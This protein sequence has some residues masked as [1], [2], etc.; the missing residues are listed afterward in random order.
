MESAKSFL[1]RMKN[2]EDFRKKVTECKDTD[3]PMNFV[4]SQGFDFTADDIEFAKGEL[5]DEDIGNISGG[6]HWWGCI[7]NPLKPLEG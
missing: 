2:D 6:T 5:S 4:K 1:E 7:N 3:G